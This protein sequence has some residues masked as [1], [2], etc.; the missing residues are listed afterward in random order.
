[1][2]N[3]SRESEPCESRKWQYFLASSLITFGAGLVVIFTYRFARFI[4]CKRGKVNQRK[5]AM[6][7]PNP[8]LQKETLK[9]IKEKGTGFFNIKGHDPEVGWL[10]EAKDW[11]G[12]LISGQTTTGRILVRIM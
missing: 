7:T 12:E 3:T 5:V 4:C 2:L 6:I 1:M 10:T 9:D 11:A 8:A